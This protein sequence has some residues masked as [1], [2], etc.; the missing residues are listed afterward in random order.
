MVS[1]VR[2]RCRRYGRYRAVPLGREAAVAPRALTLLPCA[3]RRGGSGSDEMP[4]LSGAGVGPCVVCAL[5]QGAKR[6][7]SR[8][9]RGRAEHLVVRRLASPSLRFRRRSR[10]S[11]GVVPLLLLRLRTRLVALA[12]QRQGYRL[13]GP[14][15]LAAR[16]RESQFEAEIPRLLEPLEQA[17]LGDPRK[18][19]WASFD[20]ASRHRR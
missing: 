5:A 12:A 13:D 8:H 10:R 20:A 11:R 18:P 2:H 9:E 19:E 14:I 7:S 15:P 3:N 1:R 4:V 6:L 17:L 16:E